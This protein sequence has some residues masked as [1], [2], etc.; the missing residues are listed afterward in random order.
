MTFVSFLVDDTYV[1]SLRCAPFFVTEEKER[2]RGGERQR[3]RERKKSNGNR[4]EKINYKV[5]FRGVRA[6]SSFP[7]ESGV[8]DRTSRYFERAE[9]GEGWRKRS[10]RE[11]RRERGRAKGPI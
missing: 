4:S 9:R 5:T 11:E 1:F 8:M 6:L 10:V 3:E 7:R 2:Q